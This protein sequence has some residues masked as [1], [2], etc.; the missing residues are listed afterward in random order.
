MRVTNGPAIQALPKAS[1]SRDDCEL[2]STPPSPTEISLPTHY[3]PTYSSHLAVSSSKMPQHPEDAPLHPFLHTSESQLQQRTGS[4]LSGDHPGNA[5]LYDTF[6]RGASSH[7]M[8]VASNPWRSTQKSPFRPQSASGSVETIGSTQVQ[9]PVHPAP[10]S[11]SQSQTRSEP[12]YVPFSQFPPQEW[13]YTSHAPLQNPSDPVAQRASLQSAS[14]AALPYSQIARRPGTPL[15]FRSEDASSSSYVQPTTSYFSEHPAHRDEYHHH[16][17]VTQQLHS[18]EGERYTGQEKDF[19]PV[20][21]PPTDAPEQDSLEYMRMDVD[22]C[23][24][25]WNQ[26]GSTAAG[27]SHRAILGLHN[28]EDSTIYHDWG[29]SQQ[30]SL[31][32]QQQH[33]PVATVR[34]MQDG[35]YTYT[36]LEQHSS[37]PTLYPRRDTTPMGRAGW[38][39]LEDTSS[40]SD[41]ML[42]GGIA[43]D[44]SSARISTCPLR[45]FIYIPSVS[46]DCSSYTDTAGGDVFSHNN[47]T[48]NYYF[49]E[50]GNLETRKQQSTRSELVRYINKSTPVYTHRFFNQFVRLHAYEAPSALFSSTIAGRR[51]CT[52]ETRSEIIGKL[53][54]WAKDTFTESSPIFWLSGLAGTGKSTIAYTV[55][56]YL[57][58]ENLLGAS[59]FCSRNDP[60][61]RD[62]K[63]II[64]SIVTQLLH[65]GGALFATA[66]CALP[67]GTIL[68]DNKQHVN[69]LL[70]QPW[71]RARASEPDP[72]KRHQHLVV[73]IDALDEVENDGPE[74]VAEL[75]R[76]LLAQDTRLQGIK[77]LLT[78]RPQ[79]KIVAECRPIDHRAIYSTE[80]ISPDDATD[81]IRRYLRVELPQLHEKYPHSVESIVKH[82]AG[83]FIIAATVVRYLDPPNDPLSLPQQKK[84]LADFEN[85]NVALPK[86]NKHEFR[87]DSLY[88]VVLDQAL[89]IEGGDEHEYAKRVMYAVVTA[90]QPLTVSE[91]APLVALHSE[92]DEW[93]DTDAVT[94]IIHRFH[95]VLY[96]S[97][98]DHRVRT[99]HKSFRDF[100]LSTVRCNAHAEAAS[101]YFY[102]RTTTCLQVMEKALRFNMGGFPSSYPLDI[103]DQDLAKRIKMNIN[104]ELEYACRFWATHLSS[105]RHENERNIREA[106]VHFFRL[107][108]LFWMESMHLLKIDCRPSMHLAR[109]WA[110]HLKPQVCD[111]HHFAHL[112]QRS[113][114]PCR[115]RT[116]TCSWPQWICSGLLSSTTPQV[117]RHHTSTSVAWLLC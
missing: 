18:N 112:N 38:T 49:G 102:Y 67:L 97:G 95:A 6:H 48:A 103:D 52:P 58:E 27:G 36:T 89:P 84:R 22:Y 85:M 10:F 30:H 99:Y 101:D 41:Q 79:P 24:I 98:H 37:L 59:F 68:P 45:L 91:L 104:K 57:K 86:A 113:Y 50:P 28:A 81:D 32:L 34:T 54:A 19:V 23:P 76:A 82:C 88:R 77:F 80:Q 66:L 61:A 20:Q 7:N 71:L 115:T 42:H 109:D 33:Q 105:L 69:E 5:T 40:I 44:A 16:N 75:I 31:P 1:D 12:H 14:R 116:S 107:K 65:C 73:V 26:E 93:T 111:S 47:F 21:Y 60:N 51:A 108:V 70:V 83:L 87:V 46:A 62:R 15:R 3:K 90:R 53:K 17:R 2:E 63:N 29:S 4:S 43:M 92:P 96:T 117:N 35:G 8:E 110:R 74:L 25:T 72:R 94:I 39:I 11:L 9:Q 78:S 114:D 64:P 56:Q 100:L 106:L 55:C 13:P